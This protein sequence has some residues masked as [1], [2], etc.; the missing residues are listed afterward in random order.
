[1]TRR[2]LFLFAVCV[3]AV[4]MYA[5][6]AKPATPVAPAP[7]DN[8]APD[9]STLK[10]SAPTV[11]SPNNNE[12]I[13]AATIVLRAGA[14]TLQYESATPVA[15]QYRFQVLS[16]GGTVVHDALVDDTTYEVQAALADDT[17]H[18]W[19]VRVEAQGQA[20]PWSSA[21][22]FITRDP[23]LIVD[24]LTNGRTVGIQ[25]GGNFTDIGGGGWRSNST[26]DGISYDIPT[27]ADCTVE[28]DIT[29][30][31][32]KEGEPFRRDLKFLSM[33]SAEHF[34]G[35]GAFRDSR[36]KMQLIQR[37][38]GAGT[39]L[40]I[41]WRNGRASESG[42]PGDHRIKMRPGSGG[43][44]FRNQSVF[45]FVVRWSPS[46]YH[47]SVGTNGGPQVPYLVDGFG[48]I[49]YSPPRHR[50]QLG[51]VPRSESIP[52]AIYR[53]VRIYRNR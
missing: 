53:N 41:I 36:W 50:V 3:L 28:F 30:I 27:C 15:L 43:P 9:G 10:A 51:C 2:I 8:T 38:D 21:A 14:A 22:S 17:P 46:G 4:G 7:V 45:H 5:C 16:P 37:A 24:P 20:G 29:N 40:E 19:R 13:Q 18:T 34:G 6:N 32:K 35:F 1:M 12:K 26:Q 11:Q 39:E 23:A 25:I 48:G 49:A 44:D 31:G 42:N 33:A 47:I 52:N